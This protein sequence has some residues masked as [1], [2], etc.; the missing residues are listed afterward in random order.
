MTRP[1]REA[2]QNALDGLHDYACVA[3]VLRAFGEHGYQ[4]RGSA[5]PDVLRPLPMFIGE[6][7]EQAALLL[8]AVMQMVDP[9]SQLFYDTRNGALQMAFT[10]KF[11]KPP[12]QQLQVRLRE[13]RE[14]ILSRCKL[15]NDGNYTVSDDP[16]SSLDICYFMGQFATAEHPFCPYFTLPGET[17]FIDSDYARHAPGALVNF[18]V[19]EEYIAQHPELGLK[20]IEHHRPVVTVI[21][22]E[23][24]QAALDALGITE[25]QRVSTRN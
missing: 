13:L 10:T 1:D 3:S 14:T 24:M 7:R 20:P 18:S 12:V 19:M 17:V 9:K 8:Y 4:P 25:Q 5:D 16:S 23:T 15:N 22:K 6:H 2:I 11:A 21:E